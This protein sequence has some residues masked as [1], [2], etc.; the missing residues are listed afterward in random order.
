MQYR[1]EIDGLRTVAVVPVILFH[2]GLSVFSGGYVGVDIFFVISGYLITGILI[3]ELEQGRFSILRFYERRARRIL[4][5]LFTVMLACLPFAW[6]WML[7]EQLALFGRSV[8]SV[9]FFVSNML[10]WRESDYFAAD[11]ELNPLL[12]TW[13]LAVE[14]QYYMLFPLMLAVM[15]RFGRNKTFWLICA[16]S[17]LSLALS[18]Y[19]WRNHANLNFYFAATRAWELFAGSI[20]A[21]LLSRRG[22]PWRHDLL[23]GAGLAMIVVAIFAYDDSVPFPSVWAL[24]PV[25]G[26]ALIVTCAAPGT[27]VARLLSLRGVVA[28]GLVSYSAYLWH[29]PLFAFARLRSIGE[30]SMA[31]M[32]V[33]AV[34]TFGLAWLSWRFIEQPFRVRGGDGAP[35][36][37]QRSIF[38][39]SAVGMVA[40]IAIGLIG[41][42]NQGFPNRFAPGIHAVLA[43][44]QDTNPY[45]DTC[46]FRAQTRGSLP[47]LP[48]PDCVF[49]PDPSIPSRGTVTIIGDSHAGAMAY[50]MIKALNEAGYT[51]EQVTLT[52]C[53]PLPGYTKTVRLCREAVERVMHYLET[54]DADRDHLVVA[55]R[56]QRLFL[57]GFDNGEGGHEH[58]HEPIVF[59]RAGLGLPGTASDFEAFKAAFEQGVA[60]WSSFD[61]DLT[62]IYPVPEAGWSV[63]QTMA[64]RMAFEGAEATLDTALSAY[65][66]RNSAIIDLYD[67]TLPPGTRAVRPD[68]LLCDAGTKRCLNALDGKP[69]YY[70]DDHLTNF[71]ASIIARELVT[72]LNRNDRS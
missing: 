38:T 67:A 26:T 14:E 4:P 64:K 60:R 72:A 71:G 54:T 9:M 3:R 32:M 7:P 61:S 37:S 47:A 30:P 27:W 20:C 6:I 40:F 21:F 11:S 58:G 48:N 31:L 57:P 53:Q 16:L 46:Q 70:D 43:A 24:L 34:V 19:G 59:D 50:A 44:T 17:L 15:W 69:L 22:G 45:R 23:S 51:A 33:L 65:E 18:E 8:V 5:A 56:P 55:M 25:V 1:P 41:A 68:K 66:Q 10:F 39:Y 13:S 12:H 42:L 52:G 36:V 63:P 49:P 29:Q 35:L 28:I 2:A 62:V